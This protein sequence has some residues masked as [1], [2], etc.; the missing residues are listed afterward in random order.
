MRCTRC[1]NE[2]KKEDIGVV[3]HYLITPNKILFEKRE[4]YCPICGYILARKEFNKELVGGV[5]DE[6]NES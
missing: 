4:L 2:L 6:A 1:A 3:N 5:S